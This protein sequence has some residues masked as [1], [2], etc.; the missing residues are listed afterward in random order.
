MLLL[1]ISALIKIEGKMP[2]VMRAKLPKL[3]IVSNS[4]ANAGDELIDQ[5]LTAPIKQ[6]SDE[7]RSLIMQANFGIACRKSALLTNTSVFDS[8]AICFIYNPRTKMRTE[9]QYFTDDKG[10]QLTGHSET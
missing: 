5:L 7:Q 9:T 8:R 2:D 4:L 1:L 6:L 10:K 3:N